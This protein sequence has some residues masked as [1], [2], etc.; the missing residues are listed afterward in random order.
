MVYKEAA[1]MHTVGDGEIP[2]L[3]IR[4]LNGR[5]SLK[6]LDINAVICSP[7]ESQHSDIIRTGGLNAINCVYSDLSPDYIR[8]KIAEK[9][10][11]KFNVLLVFPGGPVVDSFMYDK[12]SSALEISMEEIQ[13]PIN[14]I[15]SDD[16][17]LND[18][19][20]VP[21]DVEFILRY[22]YKYFVWT[23]YF[24]LCLLFEY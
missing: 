17:I 20:F 18:R 22:G 12:V 4:L 5:G 13:M 10:N 16:T 9:G 21:T 6:N 7:L 23:S 15:V 8:M 14:L 19:A 2:Y 24:C 3:I 1:N 11:Y